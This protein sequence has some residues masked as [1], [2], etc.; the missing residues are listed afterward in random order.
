M[1]T[2]VRLGLYAAVAVLVI[3]ITAACSIP[4][5]P[6]KVQV[7]T[8][9][10]Y[11]IPAGSTTITLSDHF[12][13]QT[14]LIAEI[15]AEL[16]EDG[17]ATGEVPDGGDVYKITADYT[18]VSLNTADFF[19]EEINLVDSVNQ[20][21]NPVTF[22]VPDIDQTNTIEEDI[23]PI[24]LPASVSLPSASVNGVPEI[25]NTNRNP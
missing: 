21:V 2:I 23:I 3:V 6:E 8:S 19:N 14:E 1:R 16:G 15:N 10:T 4:T 22:S 20:T 11:E 25:R 13:L 12:D 24:D 9:P 18:P 5:I 17:D 7:K